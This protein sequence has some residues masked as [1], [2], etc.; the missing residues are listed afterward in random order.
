MPLKDK[1]ARNA[2]NRAYKAKRR[3]DQEYKEKELEKERERYARNKDVTREKRLAKNAKYR[4]KNREILAKKER[5][6]MARIKTE[7]PVRYEEIKAGNRDR[8][9]KYRELNINNDS[10]KLRRKEYAKRRYHELKNDTDYIEA[11]RRRA[12]EWAK[13][14]RN[15]RIERTREWRAN[16]YKTDIQFKLEVCLRRRLYMA[17]RGNHRSG[18]AIRDLGCS[19]ADFKVYLESMFADGM[20]WE[21]WGINGWHIDH[22]R[23]ISSFNLTDPEQLKEACHYTNLQ[24][25][26]AKDNLRKSDSLNHVID[27]SLHARE[28]V[29]NG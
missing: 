12:N 15:R 20:S 23:P 16:R 9:I 21:N 10:H 27:C 7:N 13:K 11:N 6:R 1:E 29:K 25:L 17:V 24:P 19:I 3:R 26:W 18:I 8:G 22:K 2:Y 28:A 5:E 14:N 4:E